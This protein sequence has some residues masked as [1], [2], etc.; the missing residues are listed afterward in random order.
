MAKTIIV[1]LSPQIIAEFE[2]CYDKK[3]QERSYLYQNSSKKINEQT[4]DVFIK[5]SLNLRVMKDGAITTEETNLDELK[6][7]KIEI[8]SNPNFKAKDI[9][10]KLEEYE[11]IVGDSFYIKIANWAKLMYIQNKNY[12]KSIIE[13]A[14]EILSKDEINPKITEAA[15]KAKKDQLKKNKD[16]FKKLQKEEC[17]EVYTQTLYSNIIIDKI[18][19]E[20]KVRLDKEFKELNKPKEKKEAPIPQ[21]REK[22][23]QKRKLK[24]KIGRR[25]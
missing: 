10:G 21:T 9:A 20:E 2:S 11:I 1:K 17:L 4:G 19:A 6:F 15:I 24:Q 25:R 23:K 5:K 3:E 16:E 22:Q 14:E 18:K 13:N 12:N 7:E 8:P